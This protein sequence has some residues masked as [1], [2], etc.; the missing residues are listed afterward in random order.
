M[1]CVYA[2]RNNALRQ[3]CAGPHQMLYKY[4]SWVPVPVIPGELPANFGSLSIEQRHTAVKKVNILAH[5]MLG[6]FGA[7]C[8]VRHS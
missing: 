4:D 3:R 7:S 6:V 8:C 1:L 5:N 2:V